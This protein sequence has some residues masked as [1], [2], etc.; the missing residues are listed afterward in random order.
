MDEFDD[1]NSEISD[2]IENL[3]EEELDAYLE[4]EYRDYTLEDDEY[5][6]IP[7]TREEINYA[8]SKEKLDSYIERKGETAKP[9]GTPLERYENV[10]V[11]TRQSK[12]PTVEYVEDTVQIDGRSVTARFPEFESVKDVQ[13]PDNLRF[14]RISEQESYC[15]QM[16]RQDV[17]ENP[18]KYEGIFNEKQLEQINA[19]QKPEGF[20]WHH[21]QEVGKMQ[22]VD[23]ETHSHNR[24]D[25]GFILWGGEKR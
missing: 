7:A 6:E 4:Y 9:E 20:T 1:D 16:L 2:E 15:N 24:H 23:T 13:L 21:H 19:G 10:E 25:A 18:D 14:G 5:E 22:L 17:Q 11:T 8:L 3:S 12:H